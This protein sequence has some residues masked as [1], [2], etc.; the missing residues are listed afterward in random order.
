MNQNLAAEMG[1]FKVSEKKI[2]MPEILRALK[3]KRVEFNFIFFFNS[4]KGL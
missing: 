1:R 2:S 4:K 3:E